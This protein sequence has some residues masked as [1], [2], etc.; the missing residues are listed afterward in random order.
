M[1]EKEIKNRVAIFIDGSN[2]YHTLR[3]LFPDKKPNDFNFEKFVNYILEGRELVNVYYYNTPLDIMQDKEKYIKQQKFFDK[4]Q[5]IPKFIFVLCRM[6]KVKIDGKII[7]Q[8]KED[9]IHLAVDMVKLAFNDIYDMAILVSS[10]GDFVPAVEAVKE[11]GK[12]TRN[13]SFENKFSYHLQQKCNSFS[14]LK[15]DVVERFFD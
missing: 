13:V 1:A 6:Q 12:T 14:R 3:K 15:K 4:I 10:D 7:Y 2:V 9:D 5:R 8:V 11:R